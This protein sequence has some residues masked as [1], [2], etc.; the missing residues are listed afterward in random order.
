MKT[1]LKLSNL[2]FFF[3]SFTPTQENYYTPSEVMYALEK[4]VKHSTHY[5]DLEDMIMVP[6]KS[7]G[8]AIFELI[9]FDSDIYGNKVAIYE[10]TG[11]IS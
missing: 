2:N 4:K 8:D 5:I 6:Y 10:Y 7:D 1:S 3:D 11:T 9:S